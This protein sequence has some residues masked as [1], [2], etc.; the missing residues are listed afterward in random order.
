MPSNRRARIELE[1]RENP[2]RSNNVISEITSCSPEWV[3]HVRHDMEAAG[4][5]PVVPVARRA[6]D[7]VYGE[8]ARGRLKVGDRPSAGF[9]RLDDVDGDCCVRE[10]RNSAWQHSRS[11]PFRRQAAR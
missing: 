5:I 3:G 10:Y 6:S 1:L 8:V 2:A 4:D 7:P 11:C 9:Y